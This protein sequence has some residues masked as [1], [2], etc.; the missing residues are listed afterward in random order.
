[1]IRVLV[2]DDQ[3]AVR[4]VI[5]ALL[6][7][8]PGIEVVAEA[9]DGAEAAELAR[10]HRVDVVLMDLQMPG[11]DG[12][13]GT[14][15]T[16]RSW[17]KARVIMLTM[18]D[19]DEHVLGALRAGAS[20]FV[21]K[22]AHPHHLLAAVHGAQRGDQVFSPTIIG[23]LV[24]SYDRRA[25]Y[26]GEVPP[27]LTVLTSR[28]LEVFR[29]LAHGLSNVELAAALVVSETT[30]KTHVARILGKLGLRNRTQAVVL[31]YESG[32]L[33]PGGQPP[34]LQLTAA[35]RHRTTR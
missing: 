11:T 13:E 26:D 27:E 33:V 15:L 18:F 34:Q 31:G 9:A 21:L 6:S 32:L 25:P 24:A 30:V 29:L 23:R 2:A 8:D 7:T 14:R 4:A 35:A 22:S 20:G 17:P 16:A 5:R 19:L 12:V 10:E 28:E 3:R 1:M